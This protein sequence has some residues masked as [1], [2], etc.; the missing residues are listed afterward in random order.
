MRE[1]KKGRAKGGIITGIR[2]G[3][4]GEGDE[5]NVV[6][7]EGIQERHVKIEEDTW[8]VFIV[9]NRE[10]KAEKLK[11]LDES[12]EERKEGLLLILGDFNARIG[13]EGEI[14]LETGEEEARKSMDK[15]RNKEGEKLIELTEERGWVILNG[16]KTGDLEGD[17]TFNRGGN[18]SVIDFGLTNVE[19][20]EKIERFEIGRRVDSD[21]SPLIVTLNMGKDKEV[22]VKDKRKEKVQLWDEESEK[23]YRERTENIDWKEEGVEKEWRELK[24]KVDTETSWK[25]R[26]TRKAG[27]QPWWDTECRAGKKILQ[28]IWK[29]VGKKRV[30]E[31]EYKESRRVYKDL[32][33]EKKRKWKEKEEE[34]VRNIK[35]EKE[36]WE[37]V[38]RGR[39]SRPGTSENIGME[40]WKMYFMDLLNGNGEKRTAQEENENSTRRKPRNDEELS[41][42]QIQKAWGKLK[43]GKAAG[44][45]GI[46]NE[47]WINGGVAIK[48]KVG[49]ILKLVWKGEGFPEEWREGVIVPIFKKGS[50]EDIK[51]YRGITLTSTAYKL[52]A[53]ILNNELIKE[54]EEKGGFSETQFGFRE[55]RGAIDCVYILNHVTEKR[56]ARKKGKLH[57]IFL[58]LKAAFD[59][60]NRDTLWSMMEK[61]GVRKELIERVKEIYQETKCRVRVGKKESEVFWIEKGVR[62]GCPLS[63]TLF[64]I[65][66]AGL[67]EH[68]R[69]GQEGGVVVG[70][71]KIWSLSYA[72]DVVLL[73]EGEEELRRMIRRA[74]SYIRRL[75][76]EVSVEKTKVMVFS[77]GGGKRKDREWLWGQNKIEEV[78]SY[79]YLGYKMTRN[80]REEEQ[81]KER[82]KKARMIMGKVWG[83][84]ERKFKADVKWRLRLFDSLVKSVMMYGVE[85]WGWTEWDKMEKVQ[86]RYLKWILGLDIY[87]PGYVVMEEIK[88]DKFRIDTGERA[89]RYEERIRNDN[90]KE[91]V[92]ECW[93][94]RERDESRGVITRWGE[95][96][97][98]YFHRCGWSTKELERRRELGESVGAM[99]KER[100]RD[101]Q[102]QVRE[103]EIETSKYAKRYREIKKKGWPLYIRKGKDRNGEKFKILARARCGN[104]EKENRYWEK[105]ELRRCELCGKD[106]ET[107]EHVAW[108]CSEIRRWRGNIADLLDENGGGLSWL[109]EWID[110]KRKKRTSDE[111]Y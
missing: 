99:V 10:G 23:R 14:G 96:R 3:I 85:V 94:E 93:K 29:E 19:A 39:G 20:W 16:N 8:D 54:M 101:V 47:A 56:L 9:Y 109:C 83:I 71:K 26:A 38:N 51:N 68:L 88:R 72:D 78:K 55:G 110:K 53:S 111:H 61:R 1:H 24:E 95:K 81:V 31:E 11:E 98:K 108:K 92:K 77:K 104:E 4:E 17:W 65:Y 44:L 33:K 2:K 45:D 30:S 43:K 5:G 21:H 36:A 35:T 52:Y 76:L 57:A 15:F 90:R 49:R 13:E 41:N 84:G 40:A 60:L 34:K 91:L 25:Y 18:S 63:P 69:A 100:D 27:R 28:R 59:R 58:D 105:E 103:Y 62:Q 42:E 64:N 75:D 37:Y 22:E 107:L 46:R 89:H 79:H 106:K 12:I 7:K 66:M 102:K 86:E 87:T 50:K 80:N 70:R 6:E 48:Q 97:M 73:A 67:E 32:C 74:E 82:A